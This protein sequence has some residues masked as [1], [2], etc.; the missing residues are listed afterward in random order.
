MFGSLAQ[1]FG[2]RRRRLENDFDYD[3]LF[4][5]FCAPHLIEKPFYYGEKKYADYS[6]IE[7]SVNCGFYSDIGY[8]EHI[9]D[10]TFEY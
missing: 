4:A 1:N 8:D 5:Q 2:G 3:N 6:G 10:K 7:Y 9:V